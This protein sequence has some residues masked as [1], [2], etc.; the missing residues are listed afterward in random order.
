MRDVQQGEHVRLVQGECWSTWTKIPDYDPTDRGAALQKLIETD[1]QVRGLIYKSDQPSFEE[2]FPGYREEP[3]VK[4]D[5]TIP[6]EE[7]DRLL[8]RYR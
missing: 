4:Q 6:Q 3:I 5:W 7:F 8:A 2:Q 1:E